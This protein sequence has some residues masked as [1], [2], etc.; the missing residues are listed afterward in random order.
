MSLI[1]TP[2]RVADA[3]PVELDGPVFTVTSS[4]APVDVMVYLFYGTRELDFCTFL[5]P[6]GTIDDLTCILE[7]S[8]MIIT[9]MISEY[10]LL[11]IS[12]VPGV[13]Y[14]LHQYPPRI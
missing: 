10:H 8:S 5:I 14:L 12:T 7:T 9:G 6:F 3:T 2:I 1:E 13:L 11:E 4:Y